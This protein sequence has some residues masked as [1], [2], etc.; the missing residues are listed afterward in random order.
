MSMTFA[1]E[2]RVWS[3]SLL[4]YT[5][6]KGQ[7]TNIFS[8]KLPYSTTFLDKYEIQELLAYCKIYSYHQVGTVCTA[9]IIGNFNYS[10][11]L[12]TN[13]AP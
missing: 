3:I 1:V 9:D 5:D 10:P 11:D 2:S 4:K 13:P 6:P 8:I 7:Y 12:S